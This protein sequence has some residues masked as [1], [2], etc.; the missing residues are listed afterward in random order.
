MRC[1][2]RS[3]RATSQNCDAAHNLKVTG[4]N[5]V[6]ATRITAHIKRLNASLTGGV[7]V[8]APVEALW[9]QEG[10]KFC[11]SSAYVIRSSVSRDTEIGSKQEIGHLSQ[12]VQFLMRGVGQIEIDLV[13]L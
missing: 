8:S 7:C 11:V 9:K 6:P 10:A 1:R 2:E 12:A 4:S 13:I 3:F 5:P